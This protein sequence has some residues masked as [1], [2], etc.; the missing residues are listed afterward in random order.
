MNEIN[1]RSGF[2][3][4]FTPLAHHVCA[5]PEAW[6]EAPASEPRFRVVRIP[7]SDD[8][9]MRE[10]VV[11]KRSLASLLEDFTRG[12]EVYTVTV[13]RVESE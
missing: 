6:E 7:N 1:L 10:A 12:D 5:P 9:P 4:C 11:P 13:E 2:D 3:E 8:L